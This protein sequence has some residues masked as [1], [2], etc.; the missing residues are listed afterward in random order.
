LNRGQ[1]KTPLN[2]AGSRES[3]APG[4]NKRANAFLHQVLKELSS[5]GWEENGRET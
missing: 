3:K 2:V 1:L 4:I 5:K